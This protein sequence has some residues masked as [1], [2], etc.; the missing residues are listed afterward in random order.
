MKKK[1]IITGFLVVAGAYLL[2]TQLY[3]KKKPCTCGD[4]KKEVVEEKSE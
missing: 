2:F 3:P 1:Q 4:K